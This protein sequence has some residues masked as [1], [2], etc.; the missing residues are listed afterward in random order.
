MIYGVI[1]D[2]TNSLSSWGL[3]LMDGVSIG[4]PEQ[5]REIIDIPGGNGQLDLSTALTGG[6]PVFSN[7]EISFGLHFLRAVSGYPRTEAGFDAMYWNIVNQIHG[8]VCTLSFPWDTTKQYTGRIAVGPKNG[9]TGVFNFTVTMD[10]EPLRQDT[11]ETT[12]TKSVGTSNTSVSVTNNGMAVVPTLSST[13]ATTIT[14]NGGQTYNLAANTPAQVPGLILAHGSNTF[15]AKATGGTATL[16][17]K[18]RET[19]I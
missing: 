2:G 18:Y 17:I 19:S 14:Y 11:T 1:I 12:T 8:K 3:A 13:R 6:V 7:R 15:T 16:T 4:A 9:N 10:A 5:K